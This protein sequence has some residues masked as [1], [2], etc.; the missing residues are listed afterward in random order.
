MT[1]IRHQYLSI[2]QRYPDTILMFRLGDFYETFD[3][4]AK[5]ASE[6]LNIVLTS[7]T[8]GKGVKVPMAGIPSHSLEPYL[9]R[10]M[11]HGY[12]VA[13]CEQLSDPTTSKGLVERDVVRVVT[14]GTIVESSMLD[15]GINNFLAAVTVKDAEAGLAY[16]DITTGE[17]STTQLPLDR[18]AEEINRLSP[19]EILVPD[20]AIDT[21]RLFV[22]S[23]ETLNAK[24]FRFDNAKKLLMEHFETLSLEPLGCDLMPLATGA[25][26]AILEYLSSTQPSI[27]NQIDSLN[28]YS[29]DGFMALDPQTC[30]NLHLLNNRR[31]ATEEL[32]LFGILN[33]NKTAMGVRLLRRWIGQPLLNITDLLQRQDSVQFFFNSSARRHKTR[34][35]LSKV[36]DIERI[37]GRLKNSKIGPRDLIALKTSLV[38]AKNLLTLFH[39]DDSQ[40]I[41]WLK[42]GM[43]PLDEI[44]S[45]IEDSIEPYEAGTPGDGT[46]IR[47][48]F[49]DELDKIRNVATNARSFIAKLELKERNS[50]GIKSLKVGYNRIF[51]YYIEVSKSYLSLVPE[52]FIRRQTLVNGE[53]FIT[54]DL[55]EYETLVLNAGEQVK[56]LEKSL[57]MEIC[58]EIESE[59][60][61]LIALSKSIAQLD[62]FTS[63]AEAASRYKY[64]R[65][66]LK[67]DGVI[68]IKDGRHPMV[69]RVL[70]SGAFVPND[71]HL[72]NHDDQLLLITGPNMS[73]KST[74]LR[75]VALI[76][77]MAQIGSFVPAYS[78]T[79]SLVDRIFTRVGL[80]DNLATGQSTFMVEMVETAM[81][82]NQATKQSLVILDEIGRGTSTFDGLSIAQSVAEHIHNHPK[83]GCKT[84]FA[85]HYHELTELAST[86]PRVKNYSVTI[87]EQ[88]GKLIFLHRITEGK[89][90]K[91]YGVQVAQLAGL[92]KSVINRAKEILE[93]ME[94]SYNDKSICLP[95]IIS[96]QQIPLI[97]PYSQLIDEILDLDISEMTPIQAINK[98]YELQSKSSESK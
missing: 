48:G 64:T 56:G 20:T 83:L 22:P 19:A 60:A 12:K 65:P 79:I 67:Q 34:E 62:L 33:F 76:S 93:N 55:K 90:D 58:K 91:S 38:T 73:G 11:N 18:L 53:R 9:G 68:A 98:L 4:D 6:T 44:V 70:P 40:D 72:S 50:T 85:T 41:M 36:S 27:L 16:I 54:A 52:T 61:N 46:V 92:P 15:E 94:S 47:T 28:T 24:V 84:L 39:Q 8:M 21:I 23:F 7:R 45:L 13:I 31:H 26:G 77:L 1:P 51:G 57:Y 80:Q 17:Y 87:T 75:Q 96:N 71:L 3:D 78:A 37:V 74:Y 81:I 86:L 97:S 82:L 95:N 63:L 29:T 89:A 59:S 88:E 43:N 66:T 5:I 30:R 35:H 32:S 2:K 25:A 14:P 49:S 69:E 42:D 10:L